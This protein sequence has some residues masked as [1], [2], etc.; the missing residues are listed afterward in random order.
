MGKLTN[1]KTPWLGSLAGAVWCPKPVSPSEKY[2]GEEARLCE[3]WTLEN[4]LRKQDWELQ[5]K[6]GGARVGR[7]TDRVPRG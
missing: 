1:G 4:L 5:R 6:E 3:V 7:Y 2:E